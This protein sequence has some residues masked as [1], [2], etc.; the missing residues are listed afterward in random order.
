MYRNPIRSLRLAAA[1]LALVPL[2]LAAC[3][4]SGPTSPT[5]L[6]GAPCS[7]VDV[8]VGT[9]AEA[10]QGRSVTV[11]YTGWIYDPSKPD[12]KGTQFDSN[13]GGTPFPLTLGAQSVIP[14]FER[15][16]VGMKV[17]GTR[18]VTIPPDLAYGSQGSSDGR[19]PPYATLV[20]DITLLSVQ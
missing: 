13:V 16:I 7:I 11:T 3:S 15:G 4:D 9:G 8:T 20:F 10:T 19:I 1:A 5:I 2:L 18:R 12:N 6:P 17:G 14:G